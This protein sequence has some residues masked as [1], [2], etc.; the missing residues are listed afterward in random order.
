MRHRIELDSYEIAKCYVTCASWVRDLCQLG[1]LT[2]ANFTKFQ[3]LDMCE[4]K[5][6]L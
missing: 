1:S 3:G 6:L 5:T 2:T 4:G